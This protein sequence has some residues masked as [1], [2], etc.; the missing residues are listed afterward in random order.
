MNLKL[1]F[2]ESIES[3]LHHKLRTVLTLLGMIFGVGAVIA[4]LSIGKGAEQEALQLIDSMGLRNIIVK[5]KIF[6]ESKLKEIRESSLGLTLQDLNAVRETLP[7]LSAYSASKQVNVYALFSFAGTSDA[8]VYGVTPTHKVM[9]NL[10]IKKGR[11]LLPIDDITYAQVCVIGSRVAQ[12][13]FPGEDPLGKHIKINHAW[14]TVVG[15]LKD[16]SLTREEFQGISLKGEQNNIYIPLQTALKMFRFNL[17][18]SEI[19]EFRVRLKKGIPGS[20][21]A[22]TLVHLLKRRHKE[23]DDYEMIVPEALLEQHRKTQ[24]IFTIVMACI[25]GISLL[26]GGIG[27]MN[28]MLATVLER[29]REIGLRR[30]VGARQKDIKRQF[31]LETFGVSAMGGVLGILFGFGLSVI[32]SAFTGWAV[33]WSLSAVMLSVGVCAVIGLVFGIYPAVQASRLDPIEALRHD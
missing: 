15:I 19:D 9:A 31:I 5:A 23:T 22:A 27:I 12:V 1:E 25:A 7:F 4:M 3:L 13:L 14:L 6:E 32:I 21:A 2:I 20:T 24:N 16:K 8:N 10:G 11:F 28:I 18:E 30:A 26:V 29:T 33:G 17:L